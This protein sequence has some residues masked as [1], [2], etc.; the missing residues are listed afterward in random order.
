MII[1]D[2][3]YSSSDVIK[4][5][6][7]LKDEINWNLLIVFQTSNN[8][9]RQTLSF[10]FAK[11]LGIVHILNRVAVRHR[12]PLVFRLGT[13][14]PAPI[15]GDDSGGDLL[16]GEQDPLQTLRR[17]GYEEQNCTVRFQLPTFSTCGCKDS[18]WKTCLWSFPGFIEVTNFNFGTV[19]EVVP[20]DLGDSIAE[21]VL[22]VHNKPK[23]LHLIS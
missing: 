6:C 14:A 20:G 23:Q 15:H 3:T 21:Q 10:Q 2:Y 19:A 5:L 13:A 12:C 17:R 22:R 8:L 7:I 18:R 11:Q 1:S 9:F 4:V 16:L